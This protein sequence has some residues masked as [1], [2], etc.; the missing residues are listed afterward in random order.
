[1]RIRSSSG[2][3]AESP[4]GD[5]RF[6]PFAADLLGLL[7]RE[8]FA[9]EPAQAAAAAFLEERAAVPQAEKIHRHYAATDLAVV[10]LH[11]VFEHHAAMTPT[12]LKAFMAEFRVTHPVGVDAAGGESPV[13]KTMQAYG[14]RGTPSLVL[15][16]RAGQMRFR[17]F[18]KLDDL[19]LGDAIG[20]LLA[21]PTDTPD[22]DGA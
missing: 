18:G 5:L 12:S 4:A 3:C 20:R 8:R 21:E 19:L 22:A 7:D 16:D 2:G 11:T 9:R 6:H 10:G 17:H 14:M 1:M 13:P 15:F